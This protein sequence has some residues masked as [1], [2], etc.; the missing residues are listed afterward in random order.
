MKK[1]GVALA[2]GALFA[3]PAAFAQSAGDAVQVYGK[4]YPQFANSKTDGATAVGATVSTL[5]RAAPAAG[6]QNHKP[7]W[8]VDVQNSYVGFRGKH[9]LGG[10]MKAIYQIET[11]TDFDTGGG[12]WASRNSFV[13]LDG[14]FGTVKL[15]QMDT[16]Y[17][18]YGDVFSVFGVSS[19]NFLSNSNMFSQTGFT[20][21][22]ARFHERADNSLQY[23][24]PSFGPVKLGVQY[25]Q[26][27]PQ[28][29]GELSGNPGTTAKPN[30]VSAGVV[31]EAG[32][33]YVSAQHEIHNDYFGG[34]SGAGGL[35]NAA[36]LD[37]HSK[38]NATRLSAKIKAGAHRFS[39][40]IASMKYK[41][42]GQAAGVKFESYSH[43][44]M[45]LQWEAAWGGPWRTVVQFTQ[46]GAGT[47]T[48]TGG[49]ACTTDG[50]NG[51]MINLAVAYNL[52]KRTFTY[53]GYGKTTNGE[54]AAFDNWS[55]AN[56]ATGA[57]ITQMAIGM[58]TTF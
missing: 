27:N 48:V 35:S 18:D 45:A 24:T 42:T 26:H 8:S 6:D 58:S 28:S 34:S 7:R 41:E 22:R 37:A 11:A 9:D 52:S 15:G 55:N 17:K 23:E 38:D 4:L 10:G 25:S 31:Y 39:V 33:V 16:I 53:F 54:S 19:G 44:N 21:S 50:L 47:C 40:A 20:S 30:L 29:P 46:A 49:G 32:P 14:G 5:T 57:D 36:T 3:V 13:G 51:T 56:P 12:I 1:S 43:T 2:V